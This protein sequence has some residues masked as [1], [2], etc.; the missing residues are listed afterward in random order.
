MQSIMTPLN[1]L[2]VELPGNDDT[3][4]SIANKR[5]LVV[6]GTKGIGQGIA[7]V[8]AQQQAIVHVVGRSAADTPTSHSA[9][10]SSVQGC[11]DFVNGLN[12]EPFD[13]VVFT[14]GAWPDWKNPKTK[15]GCDK[16]IGLDVVAR[17]AVFM[18]L[19]ERGL[20]AKGCVVVGVC[21]SGMK[22]HCKE[23]TMKRVMLG[24]LSPDW[25]VIRTKLTAGL[26]HD[27]WLLQLASH[28]PEFTFIGTYPGT[29]AT[30]VLVP[31]V[32]RTIN[33]LLWGLLRLVNMPNSTEEVGLNHCALIGS[34]RGQPGIFFFD[35]RLNGRQ[36]N[37]G[38]TL[39][40]QQWVWSFLQ[41]LRESKL[42]D[43]AVEK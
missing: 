35:E 18:R 25:N 22:V 2:K 31:T 8:A 3:A 34:L 19:V 26:A 1:G 14:V 41:T 5:I 23:E 16:V 38:A 42:G 29:I 27:A 28:Y 6:G 20:C 4:R 12:V 30:D 15:D 37:P 33:T 21:A 43:K 7:E 36:C 40:F 10:L 13:A 9:D 32:G 39:S 11:T 24:E 17:Y